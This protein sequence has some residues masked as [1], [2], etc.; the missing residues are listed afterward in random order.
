MSETYCARCRRPAPA[1]TSAEYLHWEAVG[2]GSTMICPGCITGA[3]EQ[4]I[5]EATWATEGA[6]KVHE[7]RLRRMAK[8]Q[9]LVLEKSRRR[10]TQAL[11]YGCYLLLDAETTAVVAGAVAGRHGWSLADVEDFLTT[12]RD[13]R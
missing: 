1:E 5:D 6:L 12:P 7:N 11:D 10:D 9:G 3:E 2:D 4:E 13:Q 8:R